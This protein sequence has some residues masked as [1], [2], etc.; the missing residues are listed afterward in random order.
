MKVLIIGGNRFVGKKLVE[1]LINNSHD[2]TVINRSRSGPINAKK[3]KFDRNIKSDIESFD[4]SQFDCIVDMC[5]FKPEQFDLIKDSIP[6]KTNYIFVSSGAVDYINTNSFGDYAVEKLEVEKA[7]SQ[8]DLN[9]KVIRPSYIVGM[10][11]HRPRLGYYISQLKDNEPIAI[12]GDGNYPINLVFADDVVDCLVN[13]IYDVDRTY[14]T[15]T[16]AGD[17]S[18][19]INELIIFLKSKL[20]IGKHKTKDVTESLFP[21]QSFEFNN[22]KIKS[23]YGI[24]F[25]DLKQGIKKY[26]KEYNE[27]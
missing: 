15:Y 2:V 19:T 8:T 9:Y 23:K 7:L 20:T 12:D 16:I 21:N 3:F 1:K 10:G 5:L 11:N 6:N 25:T 14:E 18:I 22:T 13:M 27:L 4:F 26:I 24:E 17:E